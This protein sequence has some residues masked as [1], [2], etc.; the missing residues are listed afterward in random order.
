MLELVSNSI[1]SN[2]LLDAVTSQAATS[3]P[4][5]VANIVKTALISA[6]P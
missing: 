1:N 5:I 4:G 2:V 3:E 6:S